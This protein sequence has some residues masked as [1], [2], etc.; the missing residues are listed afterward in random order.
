[1]QISMQEMHALCTLYSRIVEYLQTTVEYIRH[2]IL[3]NTARKNKHRAAAAATHSRAIF[4]VSA[5]ICR[6]LI[7]VNQ[8]SIWK[9]LQRQSGCRNSRKL[10]SQCGAY[11]TRGGGPNQ[12][13][14]NNKSSPSFPLP[15]KERKKKK[16]RHKRGCSLFLSFFSSF[17]L[18]VLFRQTKTLFQFI[19]VQSFLFPVQFRHQRKSLTPFSFTPALFLIPT[20]SIHLQRSEPGK[21]GRNEIL[22]QPLFTAFVLSRSTQILVCSCQPS[23]APEC[24]ILFWNPE[25]QKADVDA[26]GEAAQVGGNDQLGR[27]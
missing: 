14:R 15:Q 2:L 22:A 27:Y 18:F 25:Y 11:A 16:K 7:T 8:T 23:V 21:R 4:P 26:E 20:L 6:E 19:T 3:S 5:E 24:F 10:V 9:Q 12:S 1:M 17:F 13:Q